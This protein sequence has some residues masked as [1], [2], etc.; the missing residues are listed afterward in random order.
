VQGEIKQEGKKP[1]D[2]FLETTDHWLQSWLHGDSGRN[3][4][5]KLFGS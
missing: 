2:G 3:R 4:L 5:A 1:W